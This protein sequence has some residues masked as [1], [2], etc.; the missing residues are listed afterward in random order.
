[1][2]MTCGFRFRRAPAGLRLAANPAYLL[3]I[4]RIWLGQ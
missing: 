1:M 3:E 2:R 4:Y